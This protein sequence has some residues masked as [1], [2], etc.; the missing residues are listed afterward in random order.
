MHSGGWLSV[1]CALKAWRWHGS[2]RIILGPQMWRDAH[3]LLRVIRCA[4]QLDGQRSYKHSCHKWES[5]LGRRQAGEAGSTGTCLQ[6]LMKVLISGLQN[7]QGEQP[8]QQTLPVTHSSLTTYFSNLL[9]LFRQI[10][11]G[12]M[13]MELCCK[14]E[15]SW[16]PSLKRGGQRGMRLSDVHRNK[17]TFNLHNHSSF[18]M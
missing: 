5:A 16:G 12:G 11:G 1:G 9:S 2:S 18:F 3:V 13:Q 15:A 7:L 6:A 8:L 4:S 17:Y 10:Q 14:T